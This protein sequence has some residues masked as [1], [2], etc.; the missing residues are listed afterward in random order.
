LC[1]DDDDA[2]FDGGDDDGDDDAAAV[3]SF[4]VASPLPSPSSPLVAATIALFRP[5]R[6]ERAR[7][8]R[9]PSSPRPSRRRDGDDDAHDAAVAIPR[10]RLS[11]STPPVRSVAT[12]R[13]TR[14]RD[15]G[16]RGAAPNAPLATAR[17]VLTRR[18]ALGCLG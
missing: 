6:V 1:G 5:R 10:V 11:A 15:G 16:A 4:V 18:A 9:P 7:R 13:A 12:F 3:A 17:M 2:P 14:R 8:T